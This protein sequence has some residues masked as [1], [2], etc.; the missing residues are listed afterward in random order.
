MCPPDVTASRGA[1]S[2]TVTTTHT[3]KG[4][5]LIQTPRTHKGGTADETRNSIE[6]DPPNTYTQHQ[7]LALT[8][9][10]LD[11]LRW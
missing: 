1:V 3:H 5:T 9:G 11:A 8:Q 2:G 4:L 7:T 10:S 6:S